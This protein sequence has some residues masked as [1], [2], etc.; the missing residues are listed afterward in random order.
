MISCKKM[1]NYDDAAFST[2]IISL[3]KY[4][5]SSGKGDTL[6]WERELSVI[7]TILPFRC[8]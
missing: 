8:L 5:H 3:C 7:I 6:V 2:L 1:K 4:Q